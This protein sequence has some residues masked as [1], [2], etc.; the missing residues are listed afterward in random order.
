MLILLSWLCQ[1]LFKVTL[2]LLPSED[3]ICFSACL[4][5]GLALL[6]PGKSTGMLSTASIL[7]P[8]RKH[9]QTAFL[10]MGYFSVLA[11]LALQS[12]LGEDLERLRTEASVRFKGSSTI[13][14]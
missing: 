4:A 1:V 6:G 7:A 5:T 14:K 8:N 9:L 11:T 13:L 3:G 10:M 2:Q 12:L